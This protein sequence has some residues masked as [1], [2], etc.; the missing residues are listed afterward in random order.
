MLKKKRKEIS[1]SIVGC[2]RVAQHYCKMLKKL[3]RKYN[4]RI[5]G[6]CDLNL[7]KAKKISKLL[8]STTYKNFDEMLHVTN[9]DILFVLTPSGTHYSQVKKALSKG[10]NV[11]VEKP[12]A[13][14]PKQ[15]EEL[16]QLSKKKK[17]LLIVAFQNRFN[18]AINYLKKSI[19]SKKFGKIVTASV[20]LR[21]CR[22]QEYYTDGWH[23]TWKNDGGAISQQG[24]HHIDALNW[25]L[26]P[27]DKLCSINSNQINKLEAEDTTVAI[28]SL[29]NNGLSTIEITT[30]ARPRDFEAS[31]SIVG[32]KGMAKIGGIALNK[33]ETW[34][35]IKCRS[36]VRRLIN[37]NSEKVINGYGNS[38]E[39]L[40]A[41]AF[42]ALLFSKKTPVSNQHVL[43]TI[44]LIHALY[45]S[46]ENNKWINLKENI[47]SKK[48]GK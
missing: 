2:G 14:I 17:L 23:G 30:A 38:H 26:G 13:L 15:F 16:I 11:L 22:F 10:I 35:F 19:D 45:A 36:N 31:L 8:F 18:K 1:I 48:L 39:T 28:M 40:I 27:V 33:I 34:E 12:P 4:F 25:L 6:V 21:W 5:K 37:N 41:K 47:V 32:E 3:K 7:K 29:K 46:M 24:I 20:V 42:E 44:K 9:P 43:S